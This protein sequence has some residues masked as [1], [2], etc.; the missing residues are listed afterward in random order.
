MAQPATVVEFETS[1]GMFAVE[2]YSQHAPRTC[3]NFAELAKIGT[4]KKNAFTILCTPSALMI[5]SPFSQNIVL[6]LIHAKHQAT[7]MEQFFTG[8]SLQAIAR[9]CFIDEHILI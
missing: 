8:I 2:L 7:T 5:L 3:F 4:L 9:N 1:V 6:L